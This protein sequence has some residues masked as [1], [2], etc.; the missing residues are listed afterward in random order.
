MTST[1][2]S[3]GNYYL[4]ESLPAFADTD[5]IPDPARRQLSLR[6]RQRCAVDISRRNAGGAL[7]GSCLPEPESGQIHLPFRSICCIAALLPLS[8]SY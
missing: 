8:L 5:F 7:R 1:Y 2:S 6:G 3:S 4:N